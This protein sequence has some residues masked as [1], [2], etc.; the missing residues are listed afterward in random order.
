MVRTRR[1]RSGASLAGVFAVV[2]STDQAAKYLA[3][4]HGVALLNQGGFIALRPDMRAWFAAPTA[5]AI[6]DGVGALLVIGGVALLLHRRRR[7]TALL[8]AGLVAAGWT[9]NLLDRFGL[10]EWTAPGSVRGVVDFIPSGGR[11]RSNLADVWIALGVLLLVA[12]AA[13]RRGSS[14]GSSAD[15]ELDV[16]LGVDAGVE[17]LV[18][19]EL[20]RRRLDEDPG[21]VVLDDGITQ[22]RCS[23]EGEGQGAGLVGGD[24]HAT[25]VGDLGLRNQVADLGRGVVRQGQHGWVPS[26]VVPGRAAHPA[27]N[28]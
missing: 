4:R 14:G 20:P 7:P 28:R 5:G 13:R 26:V 3:W 15:R 17:L 18:S 2:I 9:S 24:A 1:H 10:H 11:S 23:R 25:V 19:E 6:A 8:G 27:E 21:A 12:T 22:H 16:A